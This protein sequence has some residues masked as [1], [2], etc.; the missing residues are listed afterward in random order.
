MKFI[1]LHCDT[2]YKI[3]KDEKITM[4]S[5][6]LSVDLCKMKNSGSIAQFF[7]LFVC[8]DETKTP[9][10][11]ALYMYNIFKNEMDKN[12]DI[13]KFGKSYEDLNNNI[14]CCFLTLEEGAVI[15]GSLQNLKEFFNLGVR[16]MTLTWNFPNEIGFP[17]FEMKYKDMGLTPF[18]KDVVQQMNE[19]NMIID[20]SHLSDEGFYNV[21][22]ISSKPFLASH[23]NSRTVTNHYRN[24]SDDMLK[25][26]GNKGGLAGLNFEK[27]FLGNS[28]YGRISEMVN[29]IK[30]MVN[31]GGIEIMAL[32]SDFDGIETPSEIND[33]SQMDKLYYA[34]KDNGFKESDIEKIFFKNGMRFLKDTLSGVKND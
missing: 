33:I 3:R 32:G 14:P 12:S 26:L 7:A 8:L 16:L 29:H 5:N 27:T 2:I 1:D 10:N 30:H 20:V 28:P 25:I 9:F 21:A 15:E 17:N 34:L 13:V 11:E 23:S 24:L 22:D 6:N 31:I 19:L 4:L 18:G